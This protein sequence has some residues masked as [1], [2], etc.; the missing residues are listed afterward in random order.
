MVSQILAAERSASA[1]D[2]SKAKEA[3]GWIRG[4]TGE[5]R[6]AGLALFLAGFASFSL[7]YCVQPLLPEFSRSFSISPADSSLALSLTTA[8]LAAS[9]FLSSAFSQRLGRRGLMFGSM[10]LAALLGLGEAATPDWHWFLFARALEGFLLGGVPA[11]AMAYLAEEIEPSH[12]GKSMGLYV[13]GTAFGAMVGRIGM[14][15]VAEHASWRIALGGLGV[16]CLIAA[17]GFLY[18]LPPSRN[19]RP[20]KGFSL[21]F[22][23]VAWGTHLR[24]PALLRIYAIG[25]VLTSIFVTFFNYIAFRL[26]GPPYG[27]GQMAVSLIFLTYGFGIVSSS[28]AG[29]LSCRFRRKSLLAAGFAVM[30]AGVLLTLFS[31]L[32]AICLGIGLVVTGFFIGHSVASGSVGPL[33]GLSKG[34][35]SSLYLLFYYIGAS[36]VGWMGGWVWQHGGWTAVAALTGGLALLGAA[37]SLIKKG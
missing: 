37:L 27:F 19:F 26:S 7:I 36:F 18:L 29:G 13:G 1:P 11:V 32:I 22:H 21:R 14:G 2:A 3:A 16:L 9:I 35:A 25:F 12:L 20:Q 31:S 24:N 6:K 30:L 33:A 23:L 4:G 17:L 28:V 34:H 15:V 8:F 5:Y 10:L